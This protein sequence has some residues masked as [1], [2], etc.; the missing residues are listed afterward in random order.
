MGSRTYASFAGEQNYEISHSGG[1]S[2]AVPWC[3]GFYALCCQVKPDITPQEFIDAVNATSVPA[4]IEHGGKT[5]NFG[6]IVNPAEVIKTLQ[7]SY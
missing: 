2:W 7:E 1:L 3:A 6:R 4:E 5:Y